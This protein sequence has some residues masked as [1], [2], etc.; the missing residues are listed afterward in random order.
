MED[1]PALPYCSLD[2]EGALVRHPPTFYP[3]TPLRDH[4]AFV[5]LLEHGVMMRW[6]QRREAEQDHITELILAE[7][8][9]LCERHGSELIVALLQDGER[10]T[11]TWDKT[12][13]EANGIPYADCRVPLTPELRVPVDSHPN[14]KVQRMWADCLEGSLELTVRNPERR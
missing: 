7:L 3:Q 2:D 11:E 4:S 1:Y 13:L 10:G 12:A 8:Q 14:V 5:T 9:A 6:S